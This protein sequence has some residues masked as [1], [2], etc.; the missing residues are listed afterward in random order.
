[1]LGYNPSFSTNSAFGFFLNLPASS[2]TTGNVPFPAQ[3]SRTMMG[4]VY[5]GNTV[6]SF[7]PTGPDIIWGRHLEVKLYTDDGHI[8]LK[9][10]YVT[11]TDPQVG[12][13][14]TSIV[15]IDVLSVTSLFGLGE[16]VFL[17]VTSHGTDQGANFS[18]PTDVQHHIYFGDASRQ[19]SE[20]TYASFT[21]GAIGR[22]NNDDTRFIGEDADAQGLAWGHQIIVPRVLTLG[23]IRDYQFH[24]RALNDTYICYDPNASGIAS[25]ANSGGLPERSGKGADWLMQIDSTFT[26]VPYVTY[27]E[28]GYHRIPAGVCG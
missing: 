27:P 4:W 15:L 17:A 14:Y 16:R 8:E 28:P 2:M 10:D 20:V 7:G 3:P 6:G 24:P 22:T 25:S 5:T 18:Q 12:S 19:A 1:M 13:A 26:T 23:Q 9:G 11:G 21:T